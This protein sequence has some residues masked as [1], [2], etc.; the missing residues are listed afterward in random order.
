MNYQ[1]S[2]PTDLSVNN[3]RPNRRSKLRK[4]QILHRPVGE[5]QNNFASNDD[6]S[7]P[8]QLQGPLVND[9]GYQ[10][11]QDHTSPNHAVHTNLLH[12]VL[13][14]PIPLTTF[15]QL[16]LILV[17]LSELDAIKSHLNHL[18]TRINQLQPQPSISGLLAQRS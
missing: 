7:D 5:N 11:P 10:S 6:N 1:S 15:S 9:S 17:K 13:Q 16:D 8:P 2:S 12:K 14:P 3:Q 4:S 18:N